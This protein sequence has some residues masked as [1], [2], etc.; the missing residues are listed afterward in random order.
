KTGWGSTATSTTTGGWGATASTGF[1][2]FGAKKAPPATATSAWGKGTTPAQHD[3]QV[4]KVT[5]PPNF[6]TRS[7]EVAQRN[8]PDPTRLVPVLAVTQT[9]LEARQKL[10]QRHMQ[11]LEE[12]GKQLKNR[13]AELINR[14]RALDAR[15][16]DCRSMQSA[17]LSRLLGVL[18][19]V[20]AETQVPAEFSRQ[21][22]VTE[23]DSLGAVLDRLRALAASPSAPE[24][25]TALHPEAMRAVRGHLGTQAR[26]LHIVK[27]AVFYM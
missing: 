25:L 5:L 21:M 2:G 20:S 13:G 11:T 7:W 22:R 19:H 12:T 17:V 27:E 1:A 6:D 26:A 14:E 16:Q 8:N 23:R 18:A 9:D 4:V 3:D 10:Q 15:I 24:P